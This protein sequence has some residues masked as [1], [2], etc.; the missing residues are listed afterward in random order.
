[1]TAEPEPPPFDHEQDDQS[2]VIL[3]RASRL[4]LAFTLRDG[5]WAHCLGVVPQA[6]HTWIDQMGLASVLASIEAQPG[7]SPESHPPSP[8]YQELQYDPVQN[9]EQVLLVGKFGH[10]HYSAVFTV[11]EELHPESGQGELIFDVDVADRCRTPTA[12]PSAIYAVQPAATMAGMQEDA[13]SFLVSATDR[14]FFRVQPQPPAAIL[15]RPQGPGGGLL[16]QLAA[17]PDPSDGTQRLRY[18]F[19]F[20]IH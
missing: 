8:S 13:L 18:A 4:R 14:E 5:V 10:H 6:R 9:P 11:R 12:A 1:M 19:R 16:I 20:P 15:A 7:A 2:L 3:H 17:P